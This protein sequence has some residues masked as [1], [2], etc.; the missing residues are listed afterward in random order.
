MVKST[1]FDS[2]GESILGYRLENHDGVELSSSRRLSNGF[3]ESE[4]VFSVAIIMLVSRKC[5]KSEC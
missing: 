4:E 3:S 2:V 1:R 5:S